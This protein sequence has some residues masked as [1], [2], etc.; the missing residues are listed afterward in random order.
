MGIFVLVK[1]RKKEVPKWHLAQLS[2]LRQ[3]RKIWEILL[4]EILSQFMHGLL[5]LFCNLFCSSVHLLV[6]PSVRQSPNYFTERK[7]KNFCG[8]VQFPLFCLASLLQVRD[9]LSNLSPWIHHFFLWFY[10]VGSLKA[11]IM[12]YLCIMGAKHSA[13][14]GRG[15]SEP[16]AK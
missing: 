7:R 10:I 3:V 15:F 1:V 14:P 2:C 12:A 16:L 9:G 4:V 13:W 5:G 11:G 8:G 6:F